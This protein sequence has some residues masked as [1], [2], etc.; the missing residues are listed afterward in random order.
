MF[1]KTIRD[2]GR[3]WQSGCFHHRIRSWEGA[4][5]KRRY[6]LMNPVRAGLVSTPGEW[7]FQGEIFKRDIWW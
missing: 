5:E 2:R 4:E 1:A 7:P 6:M 3:R